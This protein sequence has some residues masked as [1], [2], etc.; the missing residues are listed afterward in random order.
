MT[1]PSRACL[2]RMW[3]LSARRTTWSH[4]TCCAIS[5]P[6]LLACGRSFSSCRPLLA[7]SPVP[8]ELASPPPLLD[9]GNPPLTRGMAHRKGLL[10]LKIPIPPKLWPARLEMESGLLALANHAVKDSG[11][12]VNAVYDEEGHDT[13]F[14]MRAREE[15]YSATLHFGDGTKIDYPRFNE[16]IV[17]GKQFQDDLRYQPNLEKAAMLDV[18]ESQSLQRQIYVCTH[19]SRD[20]RCSDRG[21]PLVK[22][23][24]KE[25]QRQGLEG[26]FKV[27]EIAH[28]GGHKWV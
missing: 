21:W 25:I 12:G 19:G 26:Q 8:L 9:Y 6:R 27:G 28:V 23:L 1:R 7:R 16:D 18:G 13:H 14:P 4:P 10:L 2:S 22:A 11:V 15:V 3:L 17:R 5:R 20:C 24:R